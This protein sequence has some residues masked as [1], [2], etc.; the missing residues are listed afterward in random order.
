MNYLDKINKDYANVS[1]LITKKIRDIYVVY[2]E[3]ICDQTKI[4]NYILKYISTNKTYNLKKYVPS[5]NVKLIKNYD[6][7]TRYLNSGFTVVLDKDITFAVETKANIS[8]NVDIPTVEPTIFGPKDSLTENYQTNLGLIKRR[9]KSHHLKNKEIEI[10][11]YTKTISSIM[12]ID[13]VAKEDIVNK[14]Y[15]RLST[16]NIDG[17][18]DIRE[19]KK[20]IINENKNVFPAFKI[21][22]RPDVIASSLLNGKIV[23]LLDTSPYAIIIPS[24]L[25]DFINPIS[26]DYTKN[27][28]VNFIKLMRL[29]CFFISIIFPSLY[30]AVTTYNQETI[31][32]LLL[33]NIQ[34]QRESVPFPAIVE[35]LIT[36][37]ICEILRE[38]DTRFPSSYGSAISILGALVLGEAAV[39]AGIVSPIMIIVV[40]IT[41]IA[42]LIFTDLEIINA[43]RHWRFIFLFACS[44]Y[45]LYGI[46]IMFIIF[47]TNLC[48]YD[49]LGNPYL[50]PISPFDKTYLKDTLFKM[51]N[52]YR[53]KV[54]S[55]NR[56]KGE[57]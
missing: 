40:A 29:F 5:P 25:A 20:Y 24:F 42:S 9:I 53:S 12:Y 1:D 56:Y 4:N 26:D 7:L 10:G 30:V 36:L 38:S 22:E 11:V 15:E 23:I 45:G 13:N 27:I 32:T 33:L 34:A 47:I 2:I 8:R 37:I 50:Y 54:L 6:D 21:T 3:T 49:I 48:N 18:N 31:P 14:V 46:C 17:I 39:S 28:N 19:L 43:I 16:I 57:K 35:C 41:F 44:L 52:H 55:K 51:K